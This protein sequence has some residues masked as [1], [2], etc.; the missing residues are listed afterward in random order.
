MSRYFFE[1]H[2]GDGLTRDL[3]GLELPT[4][5]TILNE[6]SRVMLDVAR[7]ELP[8]RET[9]AVCVIVRNEA[10]QVIS[11]ANLTFSNRWLEV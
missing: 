1:L 4:R 7:E 6:I 8:E 9:G 5:E 11:V 3:E 2:N 10:G